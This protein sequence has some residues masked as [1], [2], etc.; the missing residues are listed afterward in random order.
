MAIKTVW[1]DDNNEQHRIEIVRTYHPES[2]IDL[3]VQCGW[4]EARV[5]LSTEEFNELC[6][7][8][9]MGM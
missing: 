1:T 3:Y 9:G 4:G 7:K 2:K 5:G 8:A 6:R